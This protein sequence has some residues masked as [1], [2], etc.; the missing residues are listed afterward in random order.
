VSHGTGFA[1][2]LVEYAIKRDWPKEPE[3]VARQQEEAHTNGAR[4]AV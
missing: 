1:L 4:D 2:G 3:R